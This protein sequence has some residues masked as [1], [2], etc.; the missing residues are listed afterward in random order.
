MAQATENIEKENNSKAR[1]IQKGWFFLIGGLT[2]I[3]MFLIIST[4]AELIW[5]PK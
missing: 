1:A 3:F 5:V 2:I 4:T